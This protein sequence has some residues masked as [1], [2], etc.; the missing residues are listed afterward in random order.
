[1]RA[2]RQNRGDPKETRLRYLFVHQNFPGQFRHAARALADD[3]ANEVVGVGEVRNLKGRPPLHPRIKVIGYELKVGAGA[4]THAYLR[5]F[6]GHVRRGQEVARLLLQLRDKAGF[7]PDVVVSHP[8]WGESLF[9]RDVF[10]DARHVQYS[11]YYYR[12]TGADVGFDPEFPSSMNEHLRVRIKNSTQLQSLV[13]ADAG[14]SP[15]AW[16]QGRYP[17]ELGAKIRVIHDGIDTAVAKPEPAAWIE[18]QGQR[19]AAG[20]EVV[21]Y[22]ARNLE[23]YRGF[24]VFMRMLE[25]LQALRPQA[26]VLVVGGDEVSYGRPPEAGGTWRQHF[27]KQLEGR[28]D[29]SKVFF[30]GK[31]PYADF[32]KILQVSAAHVYLT[33]PFVLSWSMLEAMAAGGVLVG[34]RTAPV[35]EVIEDGRN[36]LLV[37][38]FDVEAMAQRVADVLARPADYQGLREQARRTVLERYDL[39]TVCLPRTLE[40]LRG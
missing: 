34:S 2:R 6:E 12:A 23:P 38:F 17:P 25:K 22:V 28:V 9:L 13:S 24:H 26:R 40:F 3:P 31:V 10:P 19:L 27:T 8:G 5:D 36:G 39:A 1:V 4:Q 20:D 15:T 37:D 30:L 7:R 21:T 29:F 32:L 14:L 11:E 33:Y 18:V 35:E 16:Q